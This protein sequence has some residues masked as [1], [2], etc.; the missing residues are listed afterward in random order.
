MNPTLY[1]SGWNDIFP[2]IYVPK[3]IYVHGVMPPDNE[4]YLSLKYFDESNELDVLNNEVAIIFRRNFT[5]KNLMKSLDIHHGSS[6]YI[7]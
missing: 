7:F 4:N 1:F 3:D 6:Y 5:D 2:H